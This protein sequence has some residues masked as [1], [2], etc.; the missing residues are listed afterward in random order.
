MPVANFCV[1]FT[2]SSSSDAMVQKT[3]FDSYSFKSSSFT[4]LA[5]QHSFCHSKF[6]GPSTTKFSISV[7]ST[8]HYNFSFSILSVIK[9]NDS[10]PA[11]APPQTSHLPIKSSQHLFQFSTQVCQSFFSQN[12]R[13][14]NS[15][16]LFE[17]S[18]LSFQRPATPT[19]ITFHHNSIH[20]LSNLYLLL[21]PLFSFILITS[22]SCFFMIFNI[23]TNII[24]T[25][26]AFTKLHTNSAGLLFRLMENKSF[27]IILIM[28]FIHIFQYSAIFNKTKPF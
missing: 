4:N 3:S 28:E 10:K 11:C 6:S 26:L 23:L 7:S 20:I 9:S 22:S 5:S 17:V 18:E 12:Q 15:A 16:S 14:L 1:S 24:L 25:V 19:N 8:N 21:N 13:V 2:L 27:L